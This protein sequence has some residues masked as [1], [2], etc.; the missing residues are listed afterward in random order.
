MFSFSGNDL[1][2]KWF[3][4]VQ[5]THTP[6]SGLCRICQKST[7]TWQIKLFHCAIHSFFHSLFC[8]KKKQKQ[9]FRKTRTKIK[10]IQ[11]KLAFNMNI[12]FESFVSKVLHRFN[13]VGLLKFFVYSMKKE[14]EFLFMLFRFILN[15]L[16]ELHVTTHTKKKQNK[17]TIF[18]SGEFR[19]HLYNFFFVVGLP[20]HQMGCLF[21]K[22]KSNL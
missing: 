4:D 6:N 14:N 10:S 9:H 12:Q 13:F 2:R 1:R 11:L 16:I 3:F 17:C 7:D 18:T 21:T 22:R 5:Q 20:A 15:F 8:V 19:C